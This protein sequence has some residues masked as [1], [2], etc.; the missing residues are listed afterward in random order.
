[1]NQARAHTIDGLL[2]NQI[3][4]P[5]GPCLKSPGIVGTEHDAEIVIKPSGLSGTPL[6]LFSYASLRLLAGFYSGKEGV[7]Q[8]LSAKLDAAQAAEARG[9]LHAKAGALRAFER[10]VRAQTGKALTPEQAD[11]LLTLVQTL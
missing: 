9:N 6:F 4:A 7:A 2:Q 3:V 1:T 10:E 8:S 5:F 11:V